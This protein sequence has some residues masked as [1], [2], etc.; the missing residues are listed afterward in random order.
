MDQKRLH[1][2]NYAKLQAITVRRYLQQPKLLVTVR[3]VQIMMNAAAAF[4]KGEAAVPITVIRVIHLPIAAGTKVVQTALVR[5]KMGV[6][7]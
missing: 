3:H 2:K 1:R 4:V 7:K 5:N 6:Y